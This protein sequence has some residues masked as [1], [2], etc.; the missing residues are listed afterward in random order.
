[1]QIC[2]WLRHFQDFKGYVESF[3]F[4]PFVNERYEIVDIAEAKLTWEDGDEYGFELDVPV[5][6]EESV[7]SYRASRRIRSSQD[8]EKLRQILTN[9]RTM[10]V[11]RT[12][13]MES[14]VEAV[15]T[16]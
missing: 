16:G 3:C 5:L 15:V 4:R 8:A 12:K 7:R 1:M 11:R 13:Q 10:T 14:L 2:K 9:V 6:N